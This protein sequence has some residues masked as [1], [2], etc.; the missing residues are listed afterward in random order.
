[1]ST[2]IIL[3]VD[4]GLSRQEMDDLRY[5]LADALGEF[6][7]HRTSAHEYVL[8]R[9][10]DLREA[11][12]EDKIKQVARRIQLAR[13]LHDATLAATY[14]HTTPHAPTAIIDYY[15]SCD[16]VDL[17]AMS[18]ALD[19]LPASLFGERKGWSVLRDQG[20]LVIEGPDDQRA[21]WEE[22]GRRWLWIDEGAP[23]GA[24]R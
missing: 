17:P 3:N 19:F 5:L 22:T 10:P 7:A 15:K 16:E 11:A 20:I 21:F 12:L 18:A 2:K 9:Y 24:A 14:E 6:A 1:M 8:G 23:L 4:S 13:K